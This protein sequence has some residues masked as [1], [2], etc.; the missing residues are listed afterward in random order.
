[1]N[2]DYW[3]LKMII[4]LIIIFATVTAFNL[5]SKKPDPKKIF[6]L[7]AQPGKWFYVKY[8]VFLAILYLR[9][10]KSKFLNDSGGL[11]SKINLDWNELEQ[12]QELSSHPK[13][14]D[15]V[16]FHAV[17]KQGFYICGGLERRHEGKANGLLYIVVPGLG[18]LESSHLPKT[19]LNQ[20]PISI[21]YREMF[22]AE[23]IEFKPV[24]A[25][26]EWDVKF[27]GE[28]R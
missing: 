6:G 27:K 25:M 15:A 3:V 23:G 26:K 1:M 7:Y 2:L 21:Q 17:N 8:A 4:F 11:G 10:I 20:D 18:L 16:F 24:E 22:S 13:A 12:L 9:K 5:Y 28:M 14:F 19:T